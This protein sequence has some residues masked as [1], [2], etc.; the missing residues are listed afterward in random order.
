LNV[1]APAGAV[2]VSA[3][4]V[5]SAIVEPPELDRAKSPARC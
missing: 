4:L 5:P 1:E 2:K 3:P